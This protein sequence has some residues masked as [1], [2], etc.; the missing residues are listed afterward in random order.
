MNQQPQKPRKRYDYLNVV[1]SGEQK[2]LIKEESQKRGLT[3]SSFLRLAAL[4]EANKESFAG[5]N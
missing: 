1:L 5:T 3:M 4:K 2:K